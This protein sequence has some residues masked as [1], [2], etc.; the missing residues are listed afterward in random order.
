MTPYQ[1]LDALLEAAKGN[2]QDQFDRLERDLLSRFDGGFEGM[3]RDVYQRYLEVDKAWP[4]QTEAPASENRPLTEAALGPRL[5]IN[6]RVPEELLDW[7]ITLGAETG[8]SRSDVLSECLAAI[9]RDRELEAKIR[10]VLVE[11]PRAEVDDTE[12]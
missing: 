1:L 2:H 11:V 5:L 4:V 10:R 8:R 9:R 7:L 12:A 3:P 6:T